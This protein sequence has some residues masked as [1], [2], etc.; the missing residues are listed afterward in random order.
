MIFPVLLLGGLFANYTS[1]KEL[2]E[3][4]SFER[5]RRPISDFWSG[6]LLGT[7]LGVWAGVN[8]GPS[9]K[10]AWST[11]DR[12]VSWAL[13]ALVPSQKRLPD[14]NEPPA[15]QSQA[16][17]GMQPQVVYYPMQQQQ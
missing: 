16:E 9:L 14:D 5:S 7:I 12:V 6:V 15:G 17:P 1:S 11:L 10:S 8:Y 2:D 4:S 3:I 13:P